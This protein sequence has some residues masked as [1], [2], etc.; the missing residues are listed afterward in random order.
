MRKAP[1]SARKSML[2]VRMS[3]P[4]REMLRELAGERTES[5][6]VRALILSMYTAKFGARRALQLQAVRKK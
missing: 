4:E 5:D 6:F 2:R 3:E 1:V